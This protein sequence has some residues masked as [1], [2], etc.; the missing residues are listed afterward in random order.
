MYLHALIPIISP[1]MSTR[2]SPRLKKK[3]EECAAEA[4]AEA[5]D[6]AQWPL[7]T[8]AAKLAKFAVV[9][10]V[11]FM[12]CAGLALGVAS[13]ETTAEQQQTTYDR[14]RS[15][16]LLSF[17]INIFSWLLASGVVFG[18]CMC[19]CILYACLSL[20]TSVCVCPLLSLTYS[21]TH[22]LTHSLTLTHHCRHHPY[23]EILRPHGRPHLPLT[24][25]L[26]RR[27]RLQLYTLTHYPEFPVLKTTGTQQHGSMLDMAPRLLSLHSYLPGERRRLPLH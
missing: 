24:L 23:R 8:V 14:L 15:L 10:G 5:E 13:E 22:S 25:V 11:C 1:T 6:T 20:S 18:K 9:E 26:V 2:A 3:A 7:N 4:E 19:V 21:L 27:R 17:G 16:F 12:I